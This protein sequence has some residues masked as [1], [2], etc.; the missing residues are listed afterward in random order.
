M[1]MIDIV[2]EYG[3]P[4]GNIVERD[5]AHLEG[6]MHRTAHVWLLRKKD[7]AVQVL[8]QKR[9]LI[10]DSFPGCYDIS[11]AGHIPAG[12]DYIGSAVREI[13]EEL[14]LIVFPDEL[15]FCGDRM[16]V[17]DDVFHGRPFHER[18]YSRVFFIHGDFQDE[19]FILQK[20]EVE[21]V[22]WMELN[23]CI[24]AVEEN[25]IRHCISYKELYMVRDAYRHMA[26]KSKLKMKDGVRS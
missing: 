15:V 1:E 24:K 21:S 22:C 25:R 17:R 7:N 26:D 4:T 10:K 6:V 16:I 5:K 20:E 18:Q 11:S 13:K 19:K 9:S 2:D 8:L 12:S 23:D 3:N 14:G